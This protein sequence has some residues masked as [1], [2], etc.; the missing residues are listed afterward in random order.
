MSN[1]EAKSVEISKLQKMLE[2]LKLELD[3]AKLETIN[4]CNKNAVLQNQVDLSM[5]EKSALERELIA[6][7]ELRKEN[8]RLRVGLLGFIKLFLLVLILILSRF[9]FGSSYLILKLAHPGLLIYL[10]S[11]NNNNNILIII[12]IIIIIHRNC[13]VQFREIMWQRLPLVPPLSRILLGLVGASLENR[14]RDF[15]FY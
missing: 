10:N 14:D 8:A 7:A 2:S 5:K 3:A 4:E 9:F 13:Y 1:E 15:F 11:Y 6:M 12:I